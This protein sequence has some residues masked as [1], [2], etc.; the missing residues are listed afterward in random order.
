VIAIPAHSSGKLP[1][2][3]TKPCLL[4][5]LLTETRAAPASL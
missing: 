4:L 5:H 1:L 2:R 3:V